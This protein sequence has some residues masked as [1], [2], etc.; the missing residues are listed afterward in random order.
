MSWTCELLG[1]MLIKETGDGI[2]LV[3]WALSGNIVLEVWLSSSPIWHQGEYIPL[4][5]T[6]QMDG[7]VTM[8]IWLHDGGMICL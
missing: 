1:P 4:S 6:L 5:N 7:Y 3:N 2:N 8:V